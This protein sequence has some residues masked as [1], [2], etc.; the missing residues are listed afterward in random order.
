MKGG[1]SKEDKHCLPPTQL[2]GSL[3]FSL[4]PEIFKNLQLRLGSDQATTAD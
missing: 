1:L 3:I 2:K 4:W